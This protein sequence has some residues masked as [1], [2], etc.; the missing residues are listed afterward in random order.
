MENPEDG[1]LLTVDIALETDQ[2]IRIVKTTAAALPQAAMPRP[3]ATLNIP[4][5]ATV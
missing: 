5:P 3:E 4:M 1:Y 2:P